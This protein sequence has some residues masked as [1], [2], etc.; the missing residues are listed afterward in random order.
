MMA[1][2]N[3]PIPDDDHVM[4]AVRAALGIHKRI[5]ALW[6]E[7]DPAARNIKLEF[8][9]GIHTGEAI[10]G[11]IGAASLMNYTAIGDSV[12]MTKR[13]EESARPS[14]TLVSQAVVQA[15]GG[16]IKV[17]ALEPVRVKGHTEPEPVFQVVEI[18]E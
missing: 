13:L 10:V 1:M 9:I 4:S 11:N 18:L 7:A 14:Q 3:A 16:R 2:F 15:V 17:N 6:T 12:N 8:G 5:N